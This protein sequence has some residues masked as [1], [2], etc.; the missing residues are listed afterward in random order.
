MA[1]A[2]DRARIP[3]I[4]DTD[5]GIDIDD[6]WALAMLLK[7][8]E[9]DLRLAVSATGDTTIRAKIIA[10]MLDAADRSDV[11]VGVGLRQDDNELPQAPWVADYGLEQYPGAVHEDGVDALIRTVMDSPEPITLICIGPLPNIS[12][13]LRREPGIAARARFVGMH[14]SVYHG[15]RGKD[16]PE[17]EYNVR[18]DVPASQRV[19]GAPWAEFT[20]TPLDTCERVRLTGDRYRR[21]YE[22]TDPLTQAVIENYRI[23]ARENPHADV[24]RASTTLFDTVAVYLGFTTE[25]LVMK[26]L[27][28]RV[29]DEGLTVP[30]PAAREMNVALDWEDLDAFE[31][32]LTERL[33][34][35]VVR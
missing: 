23:W 35:E 30:D 9:L 16:T 24:E 19:F 7:S 17:A 21:V 4:L 10:R 34:G 26:N 28:I 32:F 27:P 18:A 3:V 33:V 13:A 12:A 15:Y 6:T 29:T 22:S 25:N 11:P 20:I 5:I 8:P 31:E 2:G 1:M 14:G